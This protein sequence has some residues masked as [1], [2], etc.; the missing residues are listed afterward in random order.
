MI[1]FSF[2]FRESSEEEKKLIL[3]SV[4]DVQDFSNIQCFTGKRWKNS[5]IAAVSVMGNVCTIL[6]VKMKD[7]ISTE[8]SDIY[9]FYES[10]IFHL[11]NF[12][13]KIVWKNADPTFQKDF[14]EVIAY[15]D[16]K[17]VGKERIRTVYKADVINKSDDMLYYV[18][19]HKKVFIK[20]LNKP[21]KE[22]PLPLMLPRSETGLPVDI[23]DVD[24][25]GKMEY[26]V[27]QKGDDTYCVFPENKDPQTDKKHEIESIW[28]FF[29]DY[30]DTSF[31]KEEIETAR[32]WMNEQLKDENSTLSRYFA[33]R[34]KELK[35]SKNGKV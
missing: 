12:T 16:K 21:R 13:E 23:S 24:A 4:M 5:G 27:L 30:E 35:H 28:D 18:E 9:H 6:K 31:T 17:V 34:R 1:D 15:F 14:L 32:E 3:D 10:L 7:H 22:K 33:Q 29:D 25:W 26:I 2:H 11:F 20:C 19:K 8:F